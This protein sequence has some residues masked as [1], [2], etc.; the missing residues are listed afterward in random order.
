MFAFVFKE[1]KRR[2]LAFPIKAVDVYR[3]ADYY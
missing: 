1:P 2:D 3:G